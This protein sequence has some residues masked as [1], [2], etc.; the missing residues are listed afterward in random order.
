[1]WLE[2]LVSAVAFSKSAPP[3]T[4]LYRMY[5]AIKEAVRQIPTPDALK[6][7]T[8]CK[9]KC[10][11]AMSE[12]I[13][14]VVC[15]AASCCKVHKV[16]TKCNEGFECTCGLHARFCV[17]INHVAR[18]GTPPREGRPL[19]HFNIRS[20]LK[21]KVFHFGAKTCQ[22][23]FFASQTR[24]SVARDDTDDDEC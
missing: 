21:K 3:S 7:A 19:V 20:N 11:T 12:L 23:V 24:Q 18:K 13:E 9:H 1:M 22:H 10:S 8:T 14:C 6:E 17:A 4:S 15:G 5:K 2:P 16:C